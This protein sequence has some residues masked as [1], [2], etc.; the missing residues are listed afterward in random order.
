[1]KLM[2]YYVLAG[3]TAMM[4]STKASQEATPEA[5]QKIITKLASKRDAQRKA[6]KKVTPVSITAAES[7]TST[8][9]TEASAAGKSSQATSP[10]TKP[11]PTPVASQPSQQATVAP[12]VTQA[13]TVAPAV[14][15]A[16]TAAL[17]ATQAATVAPTVTQVT[18]ATA[19]PKQEEQRSTT[20][21]PQA[22]KQPSAPVTS[23]ITSMVSFP[24]PQAT[25]VTPP[26]VVLPGAGEG[27]A[28]QPAPAAKAPNVAQKQPMDPLEELKAIHALEERTARAREKKRAVAV[29]PTSDE[30][31]DLV[32]FQFENTDLK[33]IILQ[34]GTLFNVTFLTDDM[35][36]PLPQI[37]NA[38]STKG[39]KVSFRTNKPMTKKAA[40][41]L[42][43]TILDVSGFSLVPDA[44][45][46]RYRVVASGERTTKSALPIFVGTDPAQLPNDDRMIR[47][48]YFVENGNI[49]VIAGIVDKL[50]S[51]GTSDLLILGGAKAF[52]LTEKAYN[53]RMLM[54]IVKEFDRVSIP[55]AM[56]VLKLRRADAADVKDLFDKLMG[57]AEDKSMPYMFMPPRQQPTALYFPQNT[58][59]IAEPRTNSL[60]ILGSPDSI[61][62]IENVI[63]RDID[64]DPE[65]PHS[66]LFHYD[67]K[68]ADA[69]TVKNI[70]DQTAGAFGQD[71]Q[72]G[73]VGGVRGVDKYLRPMSFIANPTSNS[74]IIRGD[75]QD[76]LMVKK[77]LDEIDE[78]QPQVSL[79]VLVIALNLSKNRGLGTQLR[80][81]AGVCKGT[82]SLLGNRVEFQT[83]GLGGQGIVERQSGTNTNNNGPVLG[84]RLMGNLLDLIS[85]AYG[86]GLP[87]GSTVLTLGADVFGVWGILQMLEAFTSVEIVANPFLLASNKQEATVVIAETRR[88]VTSLVITSNTNQQAG[89]DNYTAGLTVKIT[90]QI[91][92]DGMIGL[93]VK[94]QLSQF[95]PG[96]SS[97]NVAKIVREVDT[98]AILSDR[99]VLAIGGLIQNRTQDSVSM[100]PIL[101]KIPLLGWLFRNR[102]KTDERDNLLILISAQIINPE[103]ESAAARMTEKHVND[104]YGSLE[105]MR[106]ADNHRDPI[107]RS[108][109]EESPKSVDRRVENYIFEKPRKRARKMAEREALAPEVPVLT[110]TE[111]AE[112]NR[113]AALDTPSSEVQPQR[114]KRQP[115]VSVAHD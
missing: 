114:K 83:S 109:F 103:T 21:A 17:I 75:Y 115:K 1:M 113:E 28:Q 61:E 8:K 32:E 55:Q 74:I 99:E 67:L 108:F 35:I 66:P 58:R 107:F 54:E 27:V 13:A 85:T 76:Y 44:Q 101:G 40:W 62:R 42:F 106:Q 20:S 112:A 37:P 59:I 7:S 56:S 39:F 15:Q 5:T 105:T 4:I 93:T 3:L 23:P 38:K 26:P 31:D 53:V 60:I 52:I 92:S 51:L 57:T 12:A 22:T 65:T 43:Q 72:A 90:P 46:G 104:Y 70:L 14:T 41:A 71:T 10:S 19:S 87:A 97:L 18:A 36:D 6:G 73:K 82:N 95:S 110:P 89:F 84:D 29:D 25:V 111:I 2:S 100:N 88:V 77:L 50:R 64:K 86:P 45:P 79:E 68:Y 24:V 69:A 81:S 91:N 78:P 94:V 63:R 49:D 80:S 48:I 102:N 33:N 98:N 16:A 34:M 11:A 96:S 9:K 30:S 47:Y